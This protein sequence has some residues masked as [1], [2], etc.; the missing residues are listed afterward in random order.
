MTTP[1]KLRARYRALVQQRDEL[2]ADVARWNRMH[3]KEEK[4][5]SDTAE[6]DGL[7][8]NLARQFDGGKVDGPQ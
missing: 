1:D 2:I 8:A 3:P 7:L 4:I 6:I 5:E